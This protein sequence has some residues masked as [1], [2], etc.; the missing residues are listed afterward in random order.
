LKMLDGYVAA[1]FK[2]AAEL[3]SQVLAKASGS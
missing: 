2:K 3:T 1:A